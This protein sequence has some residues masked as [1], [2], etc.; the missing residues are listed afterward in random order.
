MK[1]EDLRIP[2]ACLDEQ[3][4]VPTR[5]INTKV[6]NMRHPQNRAK[7]C[8]YKKALFN[9]L[10]WIR[11]RVCLEIGTHTGGTSAVFQNYFDK[12][13]PIGTLLTCDIKKYVDLSSLRNV[14]QLI[15]A[16]HTTNVRSFH[17]VD[18]SEMLSPASDPVED[19]VSFNIDLIRKALK[20]RGADYVDFVFVDGDHQSESFFRDMRIAEAVL[21]PA[22]FIL[23]DDTKE[24]LH[25]CSS[26]YEDVI[27]KDPS[28]ITYDFEDWE[29]FVGCAL[30][31]KVS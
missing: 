22:K 26:C 10:V 2:S 31:G 18:D 11:P 12:Y 7:K 16:H 28:Y 6:L 5:T 1:L 14:E 19:S 13:D 27:K 21:G 20:H 29:Q 25:E 3:Y 8:F 17:R 15:V 23:I 9:A 30:V 4:E 24:E